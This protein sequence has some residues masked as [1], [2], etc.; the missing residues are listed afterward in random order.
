MLNSKDAEQDAFAQKCLIPQYGSPG[1]LEPQPAHMDEITMIQRVRSGETTLFH[2]LIRP[3][4][5]SVFL[6]ANSVIKNEAEAQEVA[7]EAFLKAFKF[8]DRLRDERTFKSWLM[9]IVMN[10]ARMRLRHNRSQLFESI[11]AHV[12]DGDEGD[13][14]PPRQFADWREIPSETLERKEIRQE[15]KRALLALGE[16]YREVFVLRDVQHF[17]IVDTARILG[18]TASSVKTRLYRARLQLREDLTPI[19]KKRWSDRLPFLKGSRPW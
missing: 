6:L 13:M 7:Q 3:Y 4:E 11:D 8:L 5:R 17:S 2:E 19:F 14:M 1:V 9:Q 16:K 12:G 15:F 18:I 10:E